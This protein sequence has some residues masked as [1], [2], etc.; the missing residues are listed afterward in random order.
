M[1]INNNISSLRSQGALFANNRA[2]GTDLQRLST[3]LRI[4]TAADDAAGL[5]ISEN[6]RTQIRGQEQAK[7]N[8]L[9]GI[10]ALSIAD[11]AMNEIHNILQRQRELAVQASS[12]TYNSEGRAF[13][14]AEI[15]ALSEE[16]GRIMSATKFN[17][18]NLL[19][20]NEEGW[21]DGNR[22]L[23]VDANA[24]KG[25]DT[26]G[27]NFKA[28]LKSGGRTA[29]TAAFNA[30]G[31]D[32]SVAITHTNNAATTWSS[33]INASVRDALVHNSTVRAVA[34]LAAADVVIG[35]VN[36]GNGDMATNAAAIDQ[37]LLHGA[38]ATGQGA[39][40]ITAGDAWRE[41]ITILDSNI[42]HVNNSRA[43]IGALINRLEHTV[44]NLTNSIANQ[45]AAESQLRDLDFAA[46]S[47][48]FTKNQILTQSA[49]AMLTQ[50]NATTQGAL[51]LI[52]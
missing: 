48:N 9:D 33:G 29:A 23:Q 42:E 7:R 16:I 4:N 38:H 14:K 40:L 37:I 6:L 17:G 49:T 13:I 39:S 47:S 5:A 50:A 1:I 20:G 45:Q 52:R 27:I 30:A 8:T 3:G 12:D 21:G 28:L 10:G 2:L 51:Q 15:N 36:G 19:D 24:Q 35:G 18:T 25:V 46:Q 11:G 31:A 41:F 34:T 44:T 22:Q 26:I 32:T 43:D